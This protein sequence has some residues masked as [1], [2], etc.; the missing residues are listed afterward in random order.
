MRR[1]GS[2]AVELRQM[3]LAR[4]HQLGRRQRIGELAGFL[5][6]LPRIDADIADREQDREP[7]RRP[8]RFPEA[9]V[10]RRFPWQRIVK[11]DRAPWRTTT[12]NTPSSSVM[13]A[14]QRRRRDQ[15]RAEQQ[16]RKWIF[17]SAGEVEQRRQLGDVEAEQIGGALGLEPLRVPGSSTRSAILSNAE[18]AI[19]ANED[20]SG[21]SNSRPKCTT[22]TAANWPKNGKPAQPHQRIEP[23]I[24]AAGR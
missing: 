15:H 5:G 2:E 21:T 3:L 20:H 12:A 8:R 1:G 7:H 16:K 14:R 17:Q 9:A 24:A 4:Q 6:D 18:S 22:R 11:E 19:T 13:R 10:A 23:H